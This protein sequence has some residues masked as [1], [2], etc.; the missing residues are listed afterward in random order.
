[1]LNVKY[2]IIEQIEFFYKQVNWVGQI[3]LFLPACKVV[4]L[5]EGDG[6]LSISLFMF[7]LISFS[8]H[9][10]V[11]VSSHFLQPTPHWSC[12]IFISFNSQFI[13]FILSTILHLI[14]IYLIWLHSDY[15]VIQP[16]CQFHFSVNP[17][18]GY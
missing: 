2:L 18:S 16:Y 9:F 10:M 8:T 3:D 11:H 13:S 6:T 15:M 5:N 7:H 1:M 14:H 17:I 4:K 12:F